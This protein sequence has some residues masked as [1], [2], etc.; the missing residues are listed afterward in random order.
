CRLLSR[1]GQ[2]TALTVSETDRA[3][4]DRTTRRLLLEALR[5][6]HVCTLVREGIVSAI[7]PEQGHGVLAPRAGEC[8]LVAQG[9]QGCFPLVAAAP[10]LEREGLL[11][12][13]VVAEHAQL[14]VRLEESKLGAP[15]HRPFSL[16]DDAGQDALCIVVLTA[17]C[18]RE[19]QLLHTLRRA[20]QV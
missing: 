11:V 8:G 16:P 5:T 6:E 19:L 18:R 14:Q 12:G 4:T 1:R 3:A 13:A 20:G 7:R 17:L 9:T 2:P 15:L 10:P